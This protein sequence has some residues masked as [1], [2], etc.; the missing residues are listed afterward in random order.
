MIRI[1]KQDIKTH[2]FT[3][4]YQD[5]RLES[6][7]LGKETLFCEHGEGSSWSVVAHDLIGAR[8]RQELIE[9]SILEVASHRN[10][11][12]ILFAFADHQKQLI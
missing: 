9:P 5:T 10:Y 11:F 3:V 8:I 1:H 6:K 4:C 12:E 7:A 2:K